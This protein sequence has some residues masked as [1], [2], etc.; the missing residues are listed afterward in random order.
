MKSALITTPAKAG[1]YHDIGALYARRGQYDEAR[2]CY[3]QAI[4]WDSTFAPSYHNLGNLFL[5][6]GQ[7]A[8][9]AELFRGALRADS[10]YALSYLALGNI[11]MQHQQ[12]ALALENYQRGLNFQPNNVQLKRNAA[13][14]A[15]FLSSAEKKVSESICSRRA[16]GQ[17]NPIP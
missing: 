15:Q 3:L 5:R 1:I 16:A 6:R 2:A 13:T 4:A 9:A 17:S 7:T 8:T 10:T 12:F 14:A 11:H